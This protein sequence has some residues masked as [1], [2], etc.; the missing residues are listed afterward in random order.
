MKAVTDWIADH[1][2]SKAFAA[3]Y[4]SASLILSL[5]VSLFWLAACV[6]VHF[7]FEAIAAAKKQQRNVVGAAFWGTKFDISLVLF[8]LWLAVYL[9][10]IFGMVGLGVAAK[11]A[12]Q[13]AVRFGAWQKIVR[14]FLLSADDIVMVIKGFFGGRKSAGKP[15]QV[16]QPS[17]TVSLGD[18]LAIGLGAVSVIL[19]LSAPILIETPWG[20]VKSILLNEMHPWPG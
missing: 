15:V 4:I 18:I 8:S 20:T 9:D 3:I 13:T 2:D 7:V 5:G 12:T 6:A 1:D 17:S 14:I 10:T 11:T 19:V 16:S